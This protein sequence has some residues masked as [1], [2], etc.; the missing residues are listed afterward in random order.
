MARPSK[1]VKASTHEKR[2]KDLRSTLSKSKVEALARALPKKKKILG[3]RPRNGEASHQSVG[4]GVDPRVPR[5]GSKR[6]VVEDNVRKMWDHIVWQKISD[7]ALRLGTV[8]ED[9]MNEYGWILTSKV[10]LF[11]E[12][13]ASVSVR[14]LHKSPYKSTDIRQKKLFTI[15]GGKLAVVPAAIATTTGS[16]QC[17]VA[18]RLSHD[19]KKALGE[20]PRL[21]GN[22]FKISQPLS[23]DPIP[24][25]SKLRFTPATKHDPSFADTK[26]AAKTEIDTKSTKPGAQIK[27]E[28]K[29]KLQ[30][31]NM[32]DYE[33]DTDVPEEELVSPRTQRRSNG[34]G[35]KYRYRY[36]KDLQN[37]IAEEETDVESDGSYRDENSGDSDDSLSVDE[38]TE[39]EEEEEPLSDDEMDM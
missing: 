20:D 2:S 29:V 37:F 34:S 28:V 12:E 10:P 30:E 33:N 31:I 27:G 15:T 38:S 18:F 39:G 3:E 19:I 17:T 32:S 16:R 21:Q 36:P 22:L 26:P 6:S 1:G 4:R 35:K 14:F 24:A 7:E 9:E 25:T 11:H 23:L 13:V 5:I 8:R